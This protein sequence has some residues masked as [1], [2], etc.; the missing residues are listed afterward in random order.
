MT[1][2][3]FDSRALPSGAGGFELGAGAVFGSESQPPIKKATRTDTNAAAS[4]NLK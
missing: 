2:A 1:G 4:L 3:G